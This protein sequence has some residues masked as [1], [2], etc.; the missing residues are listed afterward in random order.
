M[1]DLF[2]KSSG[3]QRCYGKID[4]VYHKKLRK[5]LECWPNMEYKIK[6]CSYVSYVMCTALQ[7]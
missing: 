7:N 1:F 6:D 2:A 3:N 5:I 4:K